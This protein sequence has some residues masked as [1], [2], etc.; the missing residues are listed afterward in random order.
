MTTRLAP[1]LP[2]L[3]AG[4]TVLLW[5]SAF[6]AIR[7]VGTDF[8]PGALTLGRLLVASVVL[9]ALLLARGVTV[10]RRPAGT[11]DRWPA[12]SHWWL[13]AVCGVT[14]FGAYNV[15]LNAAE[16]RVDAGTA[17]MLVNIGPVLIAVL[18]GLLLGEG[19]PGGLAAGG[20]VAF[21]GVVLIAVA[22]PGRQAD[23]WGVLLGLVAAV[24][25]A[26]GVVAQ[27]PLLASASA[28]P[29][30]WLAATVGVV[31]CLPFAPALLREV[32]AAD[33]PAVGWLLYLGV[34]PT[35]LAFT[36]WAYALARTSAGRLAATTYLVPSVTVLLAWV[37]LDE[38]PAALALLGG[39]L[40][41]GGVY[42][43]RRPAR[44]TT[45]G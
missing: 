34:F 29:V 43:S 37:L 16:Q 28:L 22:T 20:A 35:A 12:R 13:V 8:S 21:A 27:K 18:A 44:R 32:A 19:F 23:R 15:A 42:L 17:A 24:T 41:L 40:C 7:H 30:T 31:V 11:A 45:D 4:V 25:Y 2:L 36:T 26:V 14:W 1:V 6:V 33:V 9:G 39:A 10:A 3:A 5:A 38:V